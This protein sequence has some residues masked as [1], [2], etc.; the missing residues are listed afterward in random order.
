MNYEPGEWAFFVGAGI[1]IQS[2]F[3]AAMGLIDSI[4]CRVAPDPGA[5]RQLRAVAFATDQER[6]A[7]G[8]YLRFEL[9]LDILQGHV[10]PDLHLLDFIPRVTEPNPVHLLLAKE[11]LAGSCIL[12]TNFDGLIEEAI[13]R[14]GGQPVTVCRSEDFPRWTPPTISRRTPVFKLHGSFREYDGTSSREALETIQ[15]TLASLTRNTPT[16][17]LPPE[18]Y[19][20]LSVVLENRPT[21]VAG[22]SGSDDLDIMPAMLKLQPAAMLWI[23][24]GPGR[25]DSVDCTLEVRGAIER[26]SAGSLSLRDRFFMRSIDSGSLKVETGPTDRLLFERFGSP[27]VGW[28]PDAVYAGLEQHLEQWSQRCLPVS[29]LRHTVVADIL[30]RLSRFTLAAEHLDK[31]WALASTGDEIGRLIARIRSKTEIRFGRPGAAVEWAQK[32]VDALTDEASPTEKVSCLHQL[33]FSAY[34]ASRREEAREGFERCLQIAETHRL[35]FWLGVLEHDMA[36]LLQDGGEYA[37]AIERYQRSIDASTAAGDIGHVAWSYFQLGTCYF[38]LG[39]FTKSREYLLK[40]EELA[41]TLGDVNHLS[42]TQ[43]ELGLLDLIS[44]RLLSAIKRFHRCLQVDRSTGQSEFS[45]ETVLQIG[46]VLLEAGKLTRA[47]ARFLQ[48]LYGL[49]SRG[50]DEYRSEALSHISQCHL[51]A[52]DV[53]SALRCSQAALEAAEQSGVPASVA[54]ARFMRGWALAE[55]EGLEGAREMG[56]AL[57]LAEERGLKALMLDLVHL[58]T[59]QR[60]KPETD[61]R[62][63]RLRAH[64]SE[65]YKRLGNTLRLETMSH[66]EP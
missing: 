4:L 63:E 13:L 17:S 51:L 55:A 7:H 9:L 6:R 30:Y 35:H 31:A 65:V 23:E 25:E 5:L 18:K 52:G 33:A 58:V 66:Y 54:R 10:D 44:G 21:L 60:L 34:R 12:T 49:E 26:A 40:S 32:A 8:D 38:D 20:F 15:A 39:E 53:E 62:L 22:Y 36:L 29:A 57:E 16:L 43:H 19:E 47:K 59:K 11:A 50:D 28:N 61:L 46:C 14:L 24:H 27:D 37:R 2:G 1:S 64:C 41:R 42:Y 45:A 48:A 3:P 56:R